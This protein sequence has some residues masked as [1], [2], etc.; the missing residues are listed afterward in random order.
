MVYCSLWEV[1]AGYWKNLAG[2][3]EKVKEKGADGI[4]WV[5][6][7][8]IPRDRS[9]YSKDGPSKKN[10]ATAPLTCRIVGC[11]LNAGQLSLPLI[12]R[13]RNKQYDSQYDCFES[14]KGPRTELKGLFQQ[15]AK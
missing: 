3:K 5:P 11:P 6:V 8:S 13:Y 7:S 10:Q 12:L 15:P 2:G 9:G 14:R 4:A 1:I